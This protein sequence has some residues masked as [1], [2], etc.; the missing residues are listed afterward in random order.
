METKFNKLLG[1][2]STDKIRLFTRLLKTNYN[3][4]YLNKLDEIFRKKRFAP[5]PFI[6]IL[7]CGFIWFNNRYYKNIYLDWPT[8]VTDYGIKSRHLSRLIQSHS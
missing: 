6:S 4:A 8:L 7:S 5:R 1:A 3:R 2:S